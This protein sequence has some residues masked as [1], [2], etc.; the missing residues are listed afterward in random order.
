MPEDLGNLMARVCFQIQ[1]GLAGKPLDGFDVTL[2]EDDRTLVFEYRPK[3]GQ[4]QAASFVLPERVDPRDFSAEPYGLT[5][6]RYI[7]FPT[8]Q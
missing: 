6:I 7:T 2:A 1:A 4:W 3:G 8:R 5:A